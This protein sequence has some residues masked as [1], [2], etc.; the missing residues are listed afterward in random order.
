MLSE[1]QAVASANAVRIGS[2]S[3]KRL[4]SETAIATFRGT[5][6]GRVTRTEARDPDAQV[7]MVK[8]IYAAA[9]VEFQQ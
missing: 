7:A 6:Q 2:L 5:V 4:D 8:A 9:N 3:V 1:A